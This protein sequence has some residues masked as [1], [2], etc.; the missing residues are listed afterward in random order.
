MASEKTTIDIPDELWKE[1]SMAVLKVYGLRKK[2]VIRE[3]L[4]KFV[5]EG[6]KGPVVMESVKQIGQ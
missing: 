1:F 6:K 3:L 4:E 5:E 2:R